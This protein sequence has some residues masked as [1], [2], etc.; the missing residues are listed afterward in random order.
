MPSPS[1]YVELAVYA[2]VFACPSIGD[3]P[4]SL[5]SWMFDWKI[6]SDVS[7]L[8]VKTVTRIQQPQPVHFTEELVQC[9]DRFP[10][11]G[12]AFD[13]EQNWYAQKSDRKKGSTETLYVRLS[14]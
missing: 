12:T 8:F 5:E 10:Y 9:V 11:L 1:L 7:V 13:S 6:T 3:V 4:N 14:Y 2:K